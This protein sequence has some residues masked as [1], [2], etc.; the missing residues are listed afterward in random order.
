MRIAVIIPAR[1]DSSRFPGKPLVEISGKSMIMRVYGQARKASGIADV[2][3]ATDDDRILDHVTSF[4]GKA[5][6]TGRHHESGTSRCAEVQEIFQEKGDVFDAIINVQGDEPYIHPVQIEQV[7]ALLGQ[8]GPAIA[9][10]VKKIIS[11]AELFSP[12]TV[13]AILSSNG[14]VLYFSRQPIPLVRDADPSQW[15]HKTDYFK[16][17]GI[18]GYQ[19]NIL[20]EIIQ[21]PPAPPEKA[22]KLEQLRWLCNG[23]E[24]VAGAT[25]Y[26]SQAVDT[27][28]DLLKLINNP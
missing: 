18:Y 3:V 1:F 7:A 14:Q 8:R 2:I 24:I 27:P 5:M 4:G 17:I 10:L 16:H 28:G 11:A 15:L 23:Y 20:R 12:D 19:S 21:L 9:T 13:K 22:E 25:E 26:E 6:L